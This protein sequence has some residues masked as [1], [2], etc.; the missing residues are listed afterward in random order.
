M[1][2]KT[3]VILF[4]TALLTGVYLVTQVAVPTKAASNELLTS[5]VSSGS[6]SGNFSSD[7]ADGHSNIESDHE[8]SNS[9]EQDDNDSSFSGGSEQGPSSDKLYSHNQMTKIQ[10]VKRGNNITF[11][12]DYQFPN[13]KKDFK[14]LVLTDPL[15]T[16][17]RFKSAKVM[18]VDE[19]K[20]DFKDITDLGKT[21][22]DKGSN[23]L[24]FTFTNPNNYWGQKVRWQIETTLNKNADLSGY[25]SSEGKI[26]IPNIAKY[27]TAYDSKVSDPV[28]VTPPKDKETPPAKADPLPETGRDNLKQ[29]GFLSS[30]GALTSD[31]IDWLIGK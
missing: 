13:D 4:S 6:D 26:E 28:K 8:T 15:E 14:K 30:L 7:E 10:V 17:F 31:V 24:T 22:L 3:K 21:S 9:S 27:D 16:P 2:L 20:N 11:I 25:M 12:I 29:K 1:V 23:I 19:K 18:T 5:S